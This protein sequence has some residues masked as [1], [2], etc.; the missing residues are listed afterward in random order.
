M[1]DKNYQTFSARFPKFF[2][3]EI[4]DYCWKNRIK[5]SDLF[6]RAIREYLDRHK[7]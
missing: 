4:E 2:A 7:S 5:R 6:R 3:Q 1:T